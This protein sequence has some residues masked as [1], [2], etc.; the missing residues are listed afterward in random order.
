MES[1]LELLAQPRRYSW[2]T[3]LFAGALAIPFAACDNAEPSPSPSFDE[4]IDRDGDGILN[5]ND[6]N[7]DLYGGPEQKL[8]LLAS[9]HALRRRSLD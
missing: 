5:L 6:R 9:M 4:V 3:L 8:R 7:P 1:E 2:R